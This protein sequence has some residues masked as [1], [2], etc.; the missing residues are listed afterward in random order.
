MLL[1]GHGVV[2]GGF[3]SVVMGTN[4]KRVWC[5]LEVV[6]TA[7]A[8]PDCNGNYRLHNLLLGFGGVEVLR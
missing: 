2:N 5:C 7:R 6:G 8:V 1:I 4:C 3:V